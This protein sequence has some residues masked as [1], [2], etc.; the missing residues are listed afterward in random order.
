MPPPVNK[1]LPQDAPEQQVLLQVQQGNEKTQIAKDILYKLLPKHGH[2]CIAELLPSKAPDEKGLMRYKWFP[3]R[4]DAIKFVMAYE[5][6]KNQLFYAQASFKESGTEWRGRRQ[7][8]AAFIKNFF[9]DIDNG[10]GKP[11]STREGS[12]EALLAFLRKTGLPEPAI[13]N[14]GNGFYAHWPFTCEVSVE[15]WIPEAKKFQ[16]LVRALAPG[17][18]HD[19]LMK[20]CARVLRPVGSIHRKDTSNPKTVTLVQDCEPIEFEVMVSLIDK[21]LAAIPAKPAAPALPSPI[22]S[23]AKH[24]NTSDQYSASGAIRIAERCAVLSHFRDTKGKVTEPLWHACIVLLVNCTE[25]PSIVHDW[26]SGHP[27]YSREQTD[28]KI[29]QCTT[30]PT[31]CAHFAGLCPDICSLCEHYGKI[32]S[33]IVLGFRGLCSAS[34][35]CRMRPG[36]D[37][38]SCGGSGCSRRP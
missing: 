11:F 7:V 2:I 35:S 18:D 4:K 12:L 37:V 14:S 19:N 32:K 17:L 10:K 28:A 16:K 22:R 26:S 1:S 29:A 23:D 21:A 27:D 8:D 15:V 24:N 31:T 20:D 30:P 38:R 34:V 13:I 9:M 36:C 6:K 33:P 3:R 5:S 25:S